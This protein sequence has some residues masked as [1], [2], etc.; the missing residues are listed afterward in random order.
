MLSHT[1]PASL[2]AA[3]RLVCTADPAQSTAQT[4]AQQAKEGASAAASQAK[5]GVTGDKPLGNAVSDAGTE[6]GG[7]A[8]DVEAL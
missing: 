6:A 4:T 5:K 8:D 3:P 1:P 7:A 2:T